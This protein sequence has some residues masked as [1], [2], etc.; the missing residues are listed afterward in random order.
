MQYVDATLQHKTAL[1]QMKQYVALR[2]NDPFGHR[3]LGFLY[4]NLNRF[5][6]AI[7]HLRQA[8]EHQPDNCYAYSKLARAHAQRYLRAKGFNPLRGGYRKAAIKYYR[9][10]RP[11]GEQPSFDKQ[12]VRNYLETSVAAGTW[13]KTAP[14]PALPDEVLDN[15]M[16]RY[17][18]AYE[19]LTGEPLVFE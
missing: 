16:A 18:E 8:L 10:A 5:S 19:R 3:F 14:G 2:P 1:K 6:N 4:L 7:D 12:Y 17:L 15:T 9:H 13:D 11:G